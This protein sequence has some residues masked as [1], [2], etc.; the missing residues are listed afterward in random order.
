MFAASFVEGFA[1]AGFV[2]ALI[3]SFLVSIVSALGNSLIE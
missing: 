1:V 3:G 2:T